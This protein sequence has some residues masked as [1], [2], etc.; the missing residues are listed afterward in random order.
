VTAEQQL[1]QLYRQAAKRLRVQ[2][3][4]DLR[5]DRIG[6]LVW[7]RRRLLAVQAELRALGQRTRAMPIDVVAA[8]YDRGAGI[9]DVVAGRATVADVVTGKVSYAF[10]GAHRRP[11]LILADNIVSRLDGARVVVGRRV[12][13]VYRR[14]GVEAVAEGVASGQTRRETSRALERRLIRDGVTGFVDRRGA[15]WQ[16][17]TYAEMVARTTTREAMSAGTRGRMTETGQDLVTISAHGADDEL[18][19]PREGVTYSIT[20]QTPGYPVMTDDDWPPFHPLCLHVATPATE[21]MDALLA[22]LGVKAE[23]GSG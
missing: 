20:G 17:D 1:I 18:C 4:A 19:G 14:A 2:I 5:D 23:T 6:S 11:A 8:G 21:N 10:V 7:R 12:E 15:Q 13:D 9:A 16:L 22:A 3:Q